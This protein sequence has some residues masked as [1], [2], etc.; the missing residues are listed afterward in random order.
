VQ[1]ALPPTGTTKL[2]DELSA[3]IPDQFINALCAAKTH[4]GTK[5]YFSPSQL[6]RTHLLA[7]LTPAHSFN[8]IVRLLPEQRQ[9]RRFAHLSHRYRTPDARMLHEFRVRVGV[10]GLRA[11]NDRLVKRLLSHI[12]P[13]SKTVAIIDATD[14]QA[15]TADKK[16]TKREVIG[17]HNGPASE[18]VRSKPATPDSLS[19]IR[20]T[21]CDYGYARINRPSY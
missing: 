8:A 6:W 7:L 12:P 10:T 18:P 13:L 14:L 5:H 11:V 4:P 17:P 15:W 16:K 20:S 2:L 3:F 1:I 19:V 21:R 9:W